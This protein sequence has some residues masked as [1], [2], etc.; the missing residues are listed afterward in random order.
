MSQNGNI[1]E[2]LLNEGLARCVDWSIGVVTEG[3]EKYRAAEKG[4]KEKKLRI[5][6]NYSASATNVHMGSVTEREFTAKVSLI[7]PRESCCV[8]HCERVGQGLPALGS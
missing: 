8:I 6:K 5:W 4:A 3:P 2:M 7:S 1:T